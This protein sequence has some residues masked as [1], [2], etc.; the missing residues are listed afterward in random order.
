MRTL[1]LLATMCFLQ[2]C[3]V[4]MESFAVFYPPD[5][6]YQ[7]ALIDALKAEAF[8]F[9]LTE[10][11]GILYATADAQTFETIRDRIG[12]EVTFT[13]SGGSV[14]VKPPSRV[15]PFAKL[16]A[17]RGIQFRTQETP[18]GTRFAYSL[19]DADLAVRL[20]AEVQAREYA[21]QRR[22]SD[23]PPE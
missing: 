7:A 18:E 15:E 1:L 3:S 16:L 17:E 5:S 8:E 13:R 10:E 2:A 4:G 19:D 14:V 22:N 9:R 21:E 6:E 12:D 11:G 20:Y 23:A